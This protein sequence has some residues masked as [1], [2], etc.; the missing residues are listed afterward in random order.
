MANTMAKR[1]KMGRINLMI[2][3][4]DCEYALRLADGLMQNYGHIFDISSYSSKESLNGALARCELKPDV[5][6]IDETFSADFIKEVTEKMMPV[7]VLML[8]EDP[9]PPTPDSICKYKH[10]SRI[11]GDVLSAYYEKGGSK[12]YARTGERNTKLIG[13]FSSAG[14]AG[15]S[16]L[17][18]C[19]AAQCAAKGYNALFVS[20][21]E[22]PSTYHFFDE[23]PNKNLSFAFYKIK[24]GGKD[25]PAAL[26]SCTVMS[27]REGLYYIPAPDDPLEF[28][29]IRREEIQEFLRNI[30]SS[31]K[32][33]HVFIDMQSGYSVITETS[34][35]DCDIVFMLTGGSVLESVKN[36][37]LS[38]VLRVKESRREADIKDVMIPVF[39]DLSG[40]CA[41]DAQA[42]FRGKK[43]NDRLP[44]D[45]ELL[46][47]SGTDPFFN[48]SSEYVR[49][50]SGILSKYVIPSGNHI[51][52]GEIS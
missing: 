23:A 51:N 52:K 12:N 2:A 33:D 48:P 1:G 46:S 47:S 34:A 19:M 26:E 30:R 27:C 9:K 18:A 8:T 32:Y 17:A 16:T 45:P 35:A 42:E 31:G 15:K 40:S 14:G 13:I 10:I 21:E 3:D 5:L 20:L 24:G 39:C 49:A 41:A 38:Q 29:E 25:V 43:I 6:L 4:G 44:F 28:N 11:S 37:R 50:V 36:E 7:S 22:I